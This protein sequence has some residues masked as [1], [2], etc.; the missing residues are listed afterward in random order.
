[1]NT[2]TVCAKL[3]MNTVV[4]LLE[5]SYSC[6][7]SNQGISFGRAMIVA[8]LVIL[9]SSVSSALDVDWPSSQFTLVLVQG[10]MSN[11]DSYYSNGFRNDN[12]SNQF[13][14]SL[15]R[16]S[17]TEA[18][19]FFQ[20]LFGVD[21]SRASMVPNS[22]CN[23]PATGRNGWNV[24]TEFVLYKNP[25]SNDPNYSNVG[26][27]RAGS[28]RDQG[29]KIP[30]NTPM[31]CEQNL[32]VTEAQPIALQ[33]YM[34]NY[35][36]AENGVGSILNAYRDCI[37]GW[38]TFSLILVNAE[39][40]W[41]AI[42]TFQGQFLS[43]DQGGGGDLLVNR[44][45]IGPYETFELIIHEEKTKQ[46]NNNNKQIN[47]LHPYFCNGGGNYYYDKAVDNKNTGQEETVVV[48]FRTHNGHYLCAENGGG[49]I[50]VADRTEIQDWEKFTLHVL[51][52]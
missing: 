31:L 1:M 30:A 27:V 13:P 34:G 2:L 19:F 4:T 37:D 40:N 17:Y 6:R 18:Q 52:Y 5:S 25:D 48:S 23:S 8:V 28:L 36:A 43:A 7:R 38:E 51:T 12:I 20:T 3:I 47:P 9:I 21:L 33:S 16:M 50:L 44:N 24:H 42:Q 22:I 41:Y 32:V 39:K 10:T 11:G 45:A 14:D 15:D 35:I 26:L 49:S 46:D 29:L